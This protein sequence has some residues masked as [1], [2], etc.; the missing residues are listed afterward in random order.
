MGGSE[1]VTPLERRHSKH[2]GKAM[3]DDAAALRWLFRFT[4]SS[5]MVGAMG[6]IHS[7]CLLNLLRG[8]GDPKFAARLA[9]ENKSVRRSVLS[10]LDY[11]GWVPGQYP[12]TAALR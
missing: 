9:G 4:T 6:E 10:A 7:A 1:E 3:A 8:Q 12:K 2:Y 5:D 11:A